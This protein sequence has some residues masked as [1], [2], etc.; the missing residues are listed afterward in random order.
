MLN[1]F[2][3]VGRLQEIKEEGVILTHQSLFKNEEGIYETFENEYVLSGSILENTK[4]YCKKG[5]L[6]GIKGS[7]RNNTL[8]AERITFLSSK[9]EEE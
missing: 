4:E 2:V 6:I 1:N 5:D 8:Y 9:K 3:V 7:I